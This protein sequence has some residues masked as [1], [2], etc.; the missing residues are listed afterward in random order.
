[1]IELSTPYGDMLFRDKP[2]P[3]TESV[4]KT[5]T[6]EPDEAKLLERLMDGR[7]GIFVDVGAHVGFFS[8]LALAKGWHVIAMEPEP[9]NY[10]LL[11]ENI[12]D[13]ER[14]QCMHAAA[15]DRAGYADLRRFD[16]NSGDNRILM[17]PGKT[18]GEIF[19]HTL[20]S[21]LSGVD[22]DANKHMIIKIDAQGRDHLVLMGAMR[23]LLKW[24]PLIIVEYWPVELRAQGY[25]PDTVIGFYD[26]LG[27]VRTP[28]GRDTLPT[29]DEY[30]SL[31]LH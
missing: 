27:Y 17:R 12:C 3:I 16:G 15:M 8:K 30:C 4:E 2:D 22:Y 13:L 23:T 9:H 29:G 11:K 1:M 31:F 5:G 18:E 26:M 7:A 14:A 21:V 19:C 6:W 10:V 20:D 28:I 25:H 24:N